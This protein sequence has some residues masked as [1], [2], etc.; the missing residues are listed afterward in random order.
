MQAHEGVALLPVA[1]MFAS[2][3]PSVCNSQA[4]LPAAAVGMNQAMQR[5]WIKVDKPSGLVKRTV[6]NTLPPVCF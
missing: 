1:R 4:K 3:R 2:S 6:C 5:K